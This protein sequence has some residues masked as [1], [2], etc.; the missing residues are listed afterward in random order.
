MYFK[1][2]THDKAKKLNES[3]LP[4]YN[5]SLFTGR[6]TILPFNSLW[7]H[8]INRKFFI[9][10]PDEYFQAKT[11]SIRAIL[12]Q[13]FPKNISGTFIDAVIEALVSENAIEKAAG[14]QDEGYVFS[15]GRELESDI[16]QDT[17][18]WLNSQE[19][20]QAVTC[21]SN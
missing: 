4:I 15:F 9:A 16:I 7:L 14:F 1:E 6:P 10:L 3:K 2:I 21:Y 12:F 18:N 17:K 13:S 19:F 11:W 5:L 8:S 20:R